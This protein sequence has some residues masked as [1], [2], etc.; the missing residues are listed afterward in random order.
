MLWLWLGLTLSQMGFAN[1]QSTHLWITDHALTHLE[2]GD[3]KNLL[4]DDAV[5]PMLRNGTM[6]P[7]GGYAVN[8]DYG[9]IAHW[10][11]FQGGYLQWIRGEH[12]P[13]F[14]DEGSQHV[15]FLM[16]L[17]SHGMA[18]QVFDSLFMERSALY[19]TW[20]DG[21]TGSL[22]T[23]SDVL[24]VRETG[25]QNVPDLW[26]PDSLFVDLFKD[27]SGHTVEARTLQTG[28]ILLGT[29]I[30]WVGNASGDEEV[31]NEYLANYPWASAHLFDPETPGSPP[32]EG[33]VIARYWSALWDR[34][35]D[36]D[37]GSDPIL[38]TVPEHKSKGHE[39]SKDKVESRI[40]IIF[41]KGLSLDALSATDFT[42]V[43]PKKHEVAFSPW[44]F[45][46][47][48]S[49]VVHL[50]LEESLEWNSRYTVTV[51]PGITAA[52]GEVSTASLSYYFKTGKDP[53]AT[54]GCDATSGPL[55]ACAL[56]GLASLIR[57]R[58]RP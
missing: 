58:R 5:R 48:D 15:A 38:S 18:D 30:T 21:L 19:D 24:F 4:V 10:E 52:D 31:V 50:V 32:C 42:V 20:G 23:A 11:D 57:I 55:S 3:L 2:D 40:T 22:D 47:N 1:G 27:I 28:Q 36:R 17:G 26:I 12:P 9:E 39:P 13:P 7:D 49:H 6:F 25:P 29:A 14:S 43:G 34:L 44:L 46:R 53:E 8:D 45:Y 51:H 54:C 37:W 56:F 16:G 41:S 33:E 35:H